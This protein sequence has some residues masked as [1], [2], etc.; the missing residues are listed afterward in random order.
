MVINMDIY[1]EIRKAYNCSESQ[2]SVAKR[3]GISRQTVKKYWK[4][5]TMPGVRKE[6]TR[7]TSV[8]TPEVQGFIKACFLEDKALGVRKQTHTAKRIYDR[9][10]AEKGFNGSY[11]SIRSAVH[12]MKEQFVPAQADM[13]LEF[14]PG[15]A[16][17]IDWGSV[18]VYLCG[19]KITV[20]IFCGRLCSSCD[21]FV[22]ACRSQ[23]SESFLESQQKMFDYFGGI[24]HRVIFD[25]AKVAV[26][27]GFGLHAKPQDTYRDFSAHYGFVT[28]FCNIASGN[29]KGLVE[30]L[31]NYVR[32]NFFVPVP[33]V[34]SMDELNERL[35]KACISYRENHK[36]QNRSETVA[37][38]YAIEKQFL[39]SIPPYNF[40][41]ARTK[42]A[43]VGDYSTVRF[44]R[45]DYSVPVRYLR[46]NVIVKG[47][48]NKVR[49]ICD[50]DCEVY[51]ERIFGQGQTEYK[52]EHYIDLLERKPR[53]VFQAKP[54][55]HNIENELLEWGKRLPGGNKDMVKLLRMCVDYG[56]ERVIEA[57]RK[58]PSSVTPS[59]DLIRSY[60]EESKKNNIIYV[61]SEIPI[62]P[63]NLI[64]YDEKCGVTAR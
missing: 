54:V 12:E 59:I 18:T 58:I 20:E 61:D 34:N 40:D 43:I 37:E 26:K 7:T 49:I 48:A 50:R 24:P 57:K 8:V 23:N 17:Q 63:S 31:V 55:L 52:L 28:E 44:E 56:Q 16:A 33:R 45:N 6:Y 30:G 25:N 4:G 29:E 64:L 2:R 11:S 60:I 62:T 5:E 3:L 38:A 13:P 27:E 1:A 32:K 46:K 47:Y 10:V 21:I 39:N 19:K 51:Y 9:L 14:A 53:S 35:H 42:T 36:I 15:D 41:T 22:N